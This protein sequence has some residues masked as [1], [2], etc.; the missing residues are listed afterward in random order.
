MKLDRAPL[1]FLQTYTDCRG[2]EVKRDFLLTG[3]RG[4]ETW[5]K[6]NK[7]MKS[8]IVEGQQKTAGRENRRRVERKSKWGREARGK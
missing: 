4:K 8:G 2:R 3:S 6:G 5:E 1:L 7:K